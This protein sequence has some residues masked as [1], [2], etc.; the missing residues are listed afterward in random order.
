MPAGSG[1]SVMDLLFYYFFP[2]SAQCMDDAQRSVVS[3]TF[4]PSPAIESAEATG[5][6]PPSSEGTAPQ[7]QLTYHCRH[8]ATLNSFY[9]QQLS[10]GIV[11]VQTN[12]GPRAYSVVPQFYLAPMEQV[13]GPGLTW[14]VFEAQRTEPVAP[15]ASTRYHVPIADGAQPDYF[16]A[17]GA[18]DPFPWS[19]DLGTGQWTH[20]LIHVG[21]V[22]LSQNNNRRAEFINLLQRIHV[23]GVNGVQ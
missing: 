16:Y 17:I 20:Q 11:F 7:L 8:E 21:Y 6:A 15:N 23:R 1:M 14:Y 18:P 5:A 13:R 22:A 10:N 12:Q 2:P 3:A 9:S 4:A 19:A